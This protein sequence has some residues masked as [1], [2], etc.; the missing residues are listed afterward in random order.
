MN[1]R[2]LRLLAVLVLPLVLLAACGD[3]G[4][5]GDVA[6]YCDLVEELDTQQDFPSDEQLDEL[7]DVA[8]AEIEDEVEFTVDRLQEDGEAAFEDPEVT[9][10]IEDIEAYEEDACGRED[11]DPVD[12]GDTDDDDDTTTTS[13]VD[14]TTTSEDTTTTSVEET[15]TTAGG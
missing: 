5:D 2:A 8:P 10:A 11:L 3:D 7:R 13:D 12:E 14:T 6:A 9:D 4:D 1:H 15:T